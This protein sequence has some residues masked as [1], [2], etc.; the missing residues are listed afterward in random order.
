VIDVRATSGGRV[1]QVLMNGDLDRA[2]GVLSA[3]VESSTAAESL[4]VAPLP[5]PRID[6]DRLW[7]REMA[8]RLAAQLDPERFGVVRAYLVGSAHHASAQPSDDIDLVLEVHDDVD[9][10]R[11]TELATWLDGWS[12]ALAAV[13]FLRTGAERERLLDV[14][15][16]TSGEV[17]RREG[18][19]ARLLAVPEA[20][21]VL[22]V[23]GGSGRSG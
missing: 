20:A 15:Y 5:E 14:R 11:R 13:N 22:P 1:L 8:E 16:V 4:W 18:E 12:R 3:P 7:R 23:K 17:A 21:R 6:D 19:A 2:V 10:A 9:P